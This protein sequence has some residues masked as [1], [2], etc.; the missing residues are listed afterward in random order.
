MSKKKSR[1]ADTIR[2]PIVEKSRTLVKETLA[3]GND[4]GLSRRTT[5]YLSEGVW[6]SLK[7]TA[8]D[9]E[10]SVSKILEGLA[11]DYLEDKK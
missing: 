5:I 3:S 6:K 7:L 10:T 11:K 1:L 8:I 4:E 9:E 2:P